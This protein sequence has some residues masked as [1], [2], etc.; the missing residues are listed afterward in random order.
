MSVLRALHS[1]SRYLRSA[2][3]RFLLSLREYAVHVGGPL[4]ILTDNSQ[5]DFLDLPLWLE[6]FRARVHTFD[7][8]VRILNPVG[9]I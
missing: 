6:S 9:M 7:P 1:Y 2:Q 4:P 5:V 3:G 8:R